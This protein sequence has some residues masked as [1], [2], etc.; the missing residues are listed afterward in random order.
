M[1]IAVVKWLGSTRGERASLTTGRASEAAAAATNAKTK[2]AAEEAAP[3]SSA[4]GAGWRS[5][6]QSAW[7]HEGRACV[8]GNWP[9]VGSRRRSD[10]RKDQDRR[11]RGRAWEQ[12]SGSWVAIAMAKRLG[13]RGGSMRHW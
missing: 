12:R 3:G 8:T 7:E 1:A 5:R 13:A 6:W 9:R 4:R 2:T 11:R 10:Q